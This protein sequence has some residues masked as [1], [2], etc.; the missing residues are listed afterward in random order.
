MTLTVLLENAAAKPFA[1][2]CVLAQKKAGT[3]PAD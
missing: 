3:R 2:Q 1:Q